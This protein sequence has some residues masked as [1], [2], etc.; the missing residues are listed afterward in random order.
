MLKSKEFTN[1]KTGE[2]VTQ[3]PVHKMRDYRETTLE[4][5]ARA[6]TTCPVCGDEKNSGQGASIVCWGSCWRGKDGLKYS[7]KTTEK[8]LSDNIKK[9]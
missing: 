5:K 8:W 9:Q 6:S 1:I 7:N 4:D 3:V 2:I